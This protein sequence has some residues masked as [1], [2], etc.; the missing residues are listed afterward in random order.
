MACMDSENNPQKIKQN[1]FTKRVKKIITDKGWNYSRNNLKPAE[2]FKKSDI[3][4]LDKIDV[5][6]KYRF[7][8]YYNYNR[9][10]PL[11]EKLNNKQ[12]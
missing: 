4:R 8:Y 1:T 2:Y 5:H 6:Y 11:F 9:Q 12:C 3:E 7:D 10:Q